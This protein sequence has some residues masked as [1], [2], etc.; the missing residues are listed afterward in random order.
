M[1]NISFYDL[2]KGKDKEVLTPTVWGC[3]KTCKNFSC[4]LPDGSTD[5]FP[6]TQE[7]RCVNT[8]FTCKLVNNYWIT[9]CRNYKQ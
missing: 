9:K 4:I 3:L 1:D 7:P 6:E 5:Y 2:L 8:D